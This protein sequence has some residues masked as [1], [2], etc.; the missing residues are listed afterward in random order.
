M[1]RAVQIQAGGRVAIVPVEEVFDFMGVD[2][3]S[4]PGTTECSQRQFRLQLSWPRFRQK[5]ISARIHTQLAR[6]KFGVVDP[7]P[8]RL[9]PV[10]WTPVGAPRRE[11]NCSDKRIGRVHVGLVFAP[12]THGVDMAYVYHP[13]DPGLRLLL[14]QLCGRRL[15]FDVDFP[16]IPE[17]A[18]RC[19]PARQ[20]IHEFG[21]G[22]R[23]PGPDLV[24]G[25]QDEELGVLL[26]RIKTPAI[27]RAGIN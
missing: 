19:T 18:Y 25:G 20:A 23:M 4:R 14:E 16:A 21:H 26:H 13:D 8:V 2:Y 1:I 10:Y 27:S 11:I 15:S 9:A 22:R 3:A 6:K 24:V 12:E 17:A 7:G 5:L